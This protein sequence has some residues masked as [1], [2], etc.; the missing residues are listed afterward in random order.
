MRFQIEM[1]GYL[2]QKIKPGPWQ[3]MGDHG[4][5]YGGNPLVTA[6]ASAVLDIFE[7]RRITEH[8]KEIGAYLYEK[9]EVYGIDSG[10][11][12]Y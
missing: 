8:V 9:L 1:H 2:L 3:D 11:G 6:G 7:K 5:T 4:T 12:L 10:G